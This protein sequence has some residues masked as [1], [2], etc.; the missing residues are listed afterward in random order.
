MISCREVTREIAGDEQQPRS[1]W[2]R[3]QLRLH[4]VMCR[5]CGEYARQIRGIGSA[6]REFLY[7]APEG[8]DPSER[9]ALARLK[10][11]L[12]GDHGSTDDPH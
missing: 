3:M 6:A 7:S 5:H 1:L 11:S 12:L 9:E 4:L 8:G 2:R 10:R